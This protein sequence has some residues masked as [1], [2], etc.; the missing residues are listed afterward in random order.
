MVSINTQLGEIVLFYADESLLRQVSEW[1][2]DSM[3]L[4]L[5]LVSSC[6][7]FSVAEAMNKAECAVIDATSKPAEAMD[8]LQLAIPLTGRD[9][10]AVYTERTHDGLELF[11]RVRGVKF[12]IGPMSE[13]E[14]EGVFPI[15]NRQNIRQW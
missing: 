10:L 4:P 8:V 12:L 15:P 11:V 6:S 3:K 13:T 5:C 1:M 14:W 2:S 7:A 9:R